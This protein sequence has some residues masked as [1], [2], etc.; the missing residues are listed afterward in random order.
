MKT[1]KHILLLLVFCILLSGCAAKPSKSVDAYMKE[2]KTNMLKDLASEDQTEQDQEINQMMK[3]MISDFEYTIGK[4]T[5]NGNSAEVEVTIKTYALGEAFENALKEYVVQA[6]AALT[7][8]DN[9]QDI[10]ALMYEIWKTKITECKEQG[11]TYSETITL[12]LEKNDKEW[13]VLHDTDIPLMNAVNGN[14][15]N[16]MQMYQN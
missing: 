1:M 3:E 5:I 11:K 14:M 6:M 4:E 12:N 8:D 15:Y 9:T 16:I 13:T 2:F 7:D 10:H